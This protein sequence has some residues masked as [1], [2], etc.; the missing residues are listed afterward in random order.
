MR[1]GA[2]GLSQISGKA[3]ARIDGRVAARDG[4]SKTVFLLDTSVN[5]QKKHASRLDETTGRGLTFERN[6]CFF[7]ELTDV[8]CKNTTFVVR[9]Q[10]F[11]FFSR[12]DFS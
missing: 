12:H 4:G 9:T 7:L 2:W 1:V 8:W 3:Y 11:H 5:S 6:Q 10:F